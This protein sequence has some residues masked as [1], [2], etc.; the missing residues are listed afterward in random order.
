MSYT[1]DARVRFSEV[2]HKGRLTLPAIEDYLQDTATFHGEEVGHGVRQNTADG[3]GWI[4][5]SL[6]AK[7]YDYP[8]IGDHIRVRTWAGK[9]SS[10]IGLR[11]FDIRDREGRTLLL[12][13][14]E[15]LMMDLAA[16]KPVKIPE[17]QVEAYGLDP[18]L[19]IQENLG[20]R[21]ILVP[22]EGGMEKEPV[23]VGE[24]M[25][26][27]NGHVNNGQYVRLSLD[28]LP[29]DVTVTALRLN[30]KKQ[31]YL[32]DIL[33]PVLY[34]LDHGWLVALNDSRQEAYFL[35]EYTVKS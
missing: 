27:T 23:P 6:Q 15:W 11:E 28:F 16:R 17:Q 31:A 21:K 3:V 19:D 7:I 33:Y 14:S 5:A 10:L 8:E 29:K 34:K 25:I 9:F 26:D 35:G 4:I 12:A 13:K 18:E 1:F 32:G 22:K 30:F 20:K 2:D 24:Y